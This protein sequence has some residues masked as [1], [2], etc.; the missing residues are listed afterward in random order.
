MN[1]RAF[2]PPPDWP[3]EPGFAPGPDW[4][5]DPAWPPAPDGWRFWT[6]TPRRTPSA[7]AVVA[8][9]GLTALLV[10]ALVG[11]ATSRPSPGE[12]PEISLELPVHEEDR[13]SSLTGVAPGWPPTSPEPFLDFAAWQ[14]FGAVHVDFADD[15]R[16]VVVD[17]RD[18]VETWRTKWSGLISTRTSAC[19]VRIVGRVRDRDHAVGRAGGFAIGLGELLPGDPVKAELAGS[20]V[21]FDFGMRG[22]RTA[23]YPADADHGVRPADLDNR[24]HD[25]EVVIDSG[26]HTLTVDGS[27]VVR[28]TAGGQCGRPFIRVW[29]GS[30]EFSDFTVTP[31]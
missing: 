12:V 15:G 20:A 6:G 17:T 5:P 31:F 25:I 8:A 10:A 27:Q 2:N 19:A 30:T 21:Q 28:T 26:S 1:G 9:V 18:T 23:V 4:A 24:W 3:V 16:T 29:A 22:F 7:A 13:E 14:S 11:V